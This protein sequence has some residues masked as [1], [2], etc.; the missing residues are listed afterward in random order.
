MC[1]QVFFPEQ[2]KVD[3]PRQIEMYIKVWDKTYAYIRIALSKTERQARNGAPL[4][5][6]QKIFCW[7]V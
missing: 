3:F 6:P 5:I 4:Y 1:R 2:R 7:L